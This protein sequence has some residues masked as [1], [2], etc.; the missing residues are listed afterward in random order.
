MWQGFNAASKTLHLQLGWSGLLWCKSW[1]HTHPMELSSITVCAEF[2]CMFPCVHVRYVLTSHLAF[3]G[4]TMTLTR[5]KQLPQMNAWCSGSCE[6]GVLKKKA[7][8]LGFTLTALKAQ[9]VKDKTFL[10]KI[11]IIK[12]SVGR[13]IQ[14]HPKRYSKWEIGKSLRPKL[15]HFKSV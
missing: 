14:M 15:H 3:L 2:P 6:H 7:G 10:N 9:I 4:F 12:L 11:N 5:I 8:C 13:K 1:N